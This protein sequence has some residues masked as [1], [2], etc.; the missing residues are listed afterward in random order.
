MA[1]NE[2]ERLPIERTPQKGEKTRITTGTNSFCYDL[3]TYRSGSDQLEALLDEFSEFSKNPM[4]LMKEFIHEAEGFLVDKGY[5][6]RETYRISYSPKQFNKDTGEEEYQAIYHVLYLYLIHHEQLPRHSLEAIYALAL[7][8][9]E[10][11]VIDEDFSRFKFKYGESQKIA[12]AYSIG[13]LSLQ[14]FIAKTQNQTKKVNSQGPRK[15]AIDEAIKAVLGKYIN[16]QMSAN[17]LWPLFIKKLEENDR[18]PVESNTRDAIEYYEE[19]DKKRTY[20]LKSFKSRLSKE[21]KKFLSG[22]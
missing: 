7:W 8:Q 12:L 17:D 16:D 2:R 9:Y 15:R 3:V 21:K 14:A 22:S 4:K 5:K 19:N 13:R 1:K 20:N 10:K 18:D 11:L 6:T